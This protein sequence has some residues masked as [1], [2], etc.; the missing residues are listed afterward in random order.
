MTIISPGNSAK[1]WIFRQLATRTEK[2]SFSVCDLAC[3]SGSAWHAFLKQHPVVSYVGFDTDKQAIA[4]AQQSFAD[5]P[6]ARFRVAD[7][8]TLKEGI[9]TFD[10]VTALSALEHVVRIDKFLDTVCSLLKPQG[11]AYVNYDNGHFHSSNI[12]ERLMVPVSQALAKVGIEGPYMKEV[13]DAAVMKMITDRGASVLRIWK[14]NVPSLKAFAKK[15]RSPDVLE[16]WFAFED[17][18]NEVAT[19]EQLSSLMGSTTVV[20]QLP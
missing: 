2:G 7:A 12:K 20:M 10:V 11:I 8:Q 5:L 18:L 13:D 19:P 9:A 16:A 14:H 3:G 1:R 4:T 15:V 6:N 17:R